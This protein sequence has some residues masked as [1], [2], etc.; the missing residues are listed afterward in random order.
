MNDK[1]EYLS[2]KHNSIT[3]DGMADLLTAFQENAELKLTYLDL[4][5]N[6]LSDV[7]GVAIVHSL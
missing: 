5:S 3:D 4:S 7:C 2:L 1:L 6:R